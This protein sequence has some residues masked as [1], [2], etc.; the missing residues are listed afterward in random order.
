MNY[1][2]SL[3]IS[4][5]FI[6]TY[7]FAQSDSYVV[8]NVVVFPNAFNTTEAE[9]FSGFPCFLDEY[10]NLIARFSIY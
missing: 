7:I 9:F 8:D 5:V 10:V 3:L 6:S 1:I 4:S 2:K